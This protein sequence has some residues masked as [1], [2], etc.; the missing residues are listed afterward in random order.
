MSS[1]HREDAD[2]SPIKPVSSLRSHFERISHAGH[3][4]QS[5]HRSKTPDSLP[6]AP[7][8]VDT[9]RHE[10][11]S[12]DNPSSR[13][14]SG[15]SNIL[16]LHGHRHSALDT[17]TQA[18]SDFSVDPAK[19]DQRFPGHAFTSQ[20][21]SPPQVTIH[22]PA[23]PPRANGTTPQAGLNTSTPVDWPLVGNQSN[24]LPRAFGP[25]LAPVP[26]RATKP[27]QKAHSV[28]RP[29]YRASISQ[30]SLGSRMTP[31]TSRSSRVDD[32]Q[33]QP[34][35]LHGTV[36]A[37]ISP[38]STPP[39]SDDG[40][41]ANV[42]EQKKPSEKQEPSAQRPEIGSSRTAIS[43]FSRVSGKLGK[44]EQGKRQESTNLG[45]APHTQQ[46][47]IKRD[48]KSVV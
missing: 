45:L 15:H 12:L 24:Q 26:N 23:T 18:V 29:E 20:R 11:L 9:Y 40:L 2:D 10:R 17:V 13:T 43:P 5:P 31:T 44:I 25:K 48:R 46:H 8:D 35:A 16:G 7:A 3:L 27:G 6:R 22:S 30:S 42:I 36:N 33:Q 21:Y 4:P 14:P 39:S 47:D 1:S 41:D 34:E 38:F 19:R 37:R 28:D 32:A